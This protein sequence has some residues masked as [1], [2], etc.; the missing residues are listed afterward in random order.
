MVKGK[1]C[2]ILRMAATGQ[3]GE[4]PKEGICIVANCDCFWTI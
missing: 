4:A 2:M 1:K 3:S